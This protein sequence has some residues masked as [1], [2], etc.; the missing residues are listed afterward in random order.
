VSRK[1]ARRA[2]R[3]GLLVVVLTLSALL[4]MGGTGIASAG[5]SVSRRGGHIGSALTDAQKQCLVNH[6]VTLPTRG[7]RRNLTPA[8]RQALRQQLVAAAQACGITFPSRP[9][10]G[11][12]RGLGLTDAQKQC[13]VNDGVTLPTG[14]NRRN[15]TPAQRQ[16]LR[17]QLVAAAQ[18][19]G[20]TLPNHGTTRT[21]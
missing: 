16:A 15:L 4:V 3:S 7:N 21:A 1:K 18:A 13:L 10:A 19:C 14:A 12:R 8:Q 11:P 6:G 20:I 2:A 5:A 17:Q 9:F